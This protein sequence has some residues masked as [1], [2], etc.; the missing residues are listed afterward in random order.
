[1]HRKP[2]RTISPERQSSHTIGLVLQGVGIVG[3]IVCFLG[4]AVGGMTATA[5]F[6]REGHPIAWWIGFFAC[7][8]LMAVGRGIRHVAARGVAGSGLVLDPERTRNDLEPWA[9]VG[10]GLVKDALDEAGLVRNDA[11]PRAMASGSRSAVA[12][13][14]RSTTKPRSSAISAARRCDR[15]GAPQGQRSVSR[16]LPCT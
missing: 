2:R 5:S 16:R 9:R 14:G 3:V 4:F 13:A 10:G 15:R 8:V 12:S 7:G 6:G 11:P 1:M